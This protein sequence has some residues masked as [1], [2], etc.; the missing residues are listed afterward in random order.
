MKRTLR[1]VAAAALFA[2]ATGAAAQSAG[3]MERPAHGF[4]LSTGLVA[5]SSGRLDTQGLGVSLAILRDRLRIEPGLSFTIIDEDSA[6]TLGYKK[7]TFSFGG[8]LFY[9]LDRTERSSIYTGGRLSLTFSDQWLSGNTTGWTKGQDVGVVLGGEYFP[10]PLVSVGLEASVG[11]LA[12]QPPGGR[13]LYVLSTRGLLILRF[14]FGAPPATTSTAT[15]AEEPAAAAPAAE[16]APVPE[17]APVA[18]PAPVAVPAPAAVPKATA[19]PKPTAVPKA[20]VPGER[21][22]P[23]KAP[24][25]SWWGE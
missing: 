19:A 7:R 5:S 24:P 25:S 3:P 8:G 13:D 15:A 14:Y 16:P 17:P 4:G 9:E 22:R 18:A 12:E 10:A 2:S 20:A 1:C 11:L 21:C 23:E 6:T